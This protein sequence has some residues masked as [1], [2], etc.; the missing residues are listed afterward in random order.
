MYLI[1]GHNKPPAVS[2]IGAYSSFEA[3]AILVLYMMLNI[4]NMPVFSLNS[5]MNTTSLPNDYI[6]HVEYIEYIEP[7]ILNILNILN[8]LMYSFECCKHKYN[9]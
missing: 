4:P 3:S 8:I 2:T 5:A 9:F 1:P 7:S 6:E